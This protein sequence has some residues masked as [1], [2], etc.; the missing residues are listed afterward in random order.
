MTVF[1]RKGSQ[2]LRDSSRKEFA[3]PQLLV[4]RA[5]SRPFSFLDR[6][7]KWLDKGLQ[8]FINAVRQLGSSVGLL[9]SAFQLRARLA[10]ILH[11]FQLNAAELF[12]DIHK[13]A[14]EPVWLLKSRSKEEWRSRPTETRIRP[15]WDIQSDPESMPDELELLAEDLNTFLE[16]LN[17]IPEFSDEAV[18]TSVTS[19]QNDL[20]YWASCLRDFK[21]I[22]YRQLLQSSLFDLN[23]INH[24]RPVSMAFR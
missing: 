19:F 15:T 21:G 4:T 18:N 16:C 22:R 3:S 17:Q 20:K 11:L 8:N 23:S 14:S 1:K 7:V 24:P 6:R 10:Q 12:D 2:T 9:S 5:E 13:D